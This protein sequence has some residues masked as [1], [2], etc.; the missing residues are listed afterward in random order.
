M[1]EDDNFLQ[2]D[3][4]IL[5]N[6][7]YMGDGGNPDW[8]EG[9]TLDPNG[10]NWR[11]CGWDGYCPGHPNDT[12]GDE[13]GTESNQQWDIGEGFEKNGKYDFN[14]IN[15]TGEYFIEF[16]PMNSKEQLHFIV[17]KINEVLGVEFKL[18]NNTPCE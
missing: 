17:D 13:N 6:E 4:I 2:H 1:H 16:M 5:P 3:L 11:D 15:S 8:E 18:N 14:I 9:S 7:N 12:N 10:D